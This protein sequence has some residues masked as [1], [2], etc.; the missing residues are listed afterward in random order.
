MHRE[1]SPLGGAGGHR[2]AV[3][4]PRHRR[5]GGVAVPLAMAALVACAPSTDPLPTR[6]LP[7]DGLATATQGGVD[8]VLTSPP[9]SRSPG[10]LTELDIRTCESF[11]SDR[12]AAHAWLLRLERRGSIPSGQ[13]EAGYRDLQTMAT[14]AETTVL[15]QTESPPLQNA[16]RAVIVEG[17]LVADALASG[18][19]V[20]PVPLRSALDAAAAACVQG[21]VAI[22]WYDG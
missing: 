2:L 20:D 19:A 21:G 12:G 6:S 1:E 9:P 18:A 22:R 4:S 13:Y 11:I 7:T 15:Y 3:H 10:Q 8:G 14:L 5:T 16:L 17:K